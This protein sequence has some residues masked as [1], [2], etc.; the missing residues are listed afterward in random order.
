MN[1]TEK[2]LLAILSDLDKNDRHSLISYAEFLLA[3]AKQEGRLLVVE[4][5]LVIPRPQEEK[6]VAAIKRLSAAYP[7]LKKNDLFNQTA[8]LMS[9]HIMQGREAVEVIDELEALFKAHY[10]AFCAERSEDGIEGASAGE[11]QE[12]Q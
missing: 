7:M 2:K 8:A 3:K 9:E 10:E 12:T 4:K 11:Q 6:V 5:P 1:K